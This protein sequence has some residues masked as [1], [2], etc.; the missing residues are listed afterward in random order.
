VNGVTAASAAPPT[1]EP[2]LVVD[3]VHTYFS[4][5]D[6]VT[7]AVDGVSF[8]VRRGES[9]GIVG[10][11]GSGKS[12]LIRS[13]MNLLPPQADEQS[14]SIR[15][16]GIEVRG[17]SRKQMR[18]L[19]AH[20][21][22][23]VFQDPM[24]SLNPVL[25]IGRQLTEAI[26]IAGERDARVVRDR[27]I[28]LLSSVGIP[29]P[30][31]RFDAYPHE[32]SGGMRQRV[33]IAIAMASNPS[34]LLADEPTTA[35]DV[36]VQRQILDLLREQQRDRSMAMILV[37]HDLGVV[38]GRTDQTAVMYAGRIVERAPTP[39]V[40]A[41]PSH[42]YTEAL[43][44]STPDLRRAPHS[45]LATIPGAPPDLS[46]V[47]AGCSFAPRCRYAQPT[48]LVESPPLRAV[49]GGDHLV[50]CH[51][52]VGTPASVEALAGNLAAG[53]T[54]AGTPVTAEAVTA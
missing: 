16:D 47:A 15:L 40:F 26:R 9:F 24:T 7:R 4:G 3:D 41:M 2:L 18:R 49:D 25:R 37:S 12:A 8:E 19:W 28:E 38:E 20:E 33:T 52:P 5:R 21:L 48:C 31:R 14:G 53:H 29:D 36:T 45:M 6:T 42:P 10:E 34:L 17:R 46:I 35:L 44:Q 43:L 50:A 27:A 22:A 13:I 11:S 1:V 54:A 30:L 51:H 39:L 23:M 32:L